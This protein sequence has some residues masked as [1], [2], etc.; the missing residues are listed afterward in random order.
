MRLFREGRFA[1]AL[2]CFDRVLAADPRHTLARGWRGLALVS[3]GELAQAEAEL[4]IAVRESPRDAFLQNGLAGLLIILDRLDEAGDCLRRALALA[5]AFPD[6][7]ANL[8]LVLRLQGDF[9]GSERAGRKALVGLPTHVQARTN[10]AFALLA[11]GKYAEAWPESCA[12]PDP[13]LNPRG[14]VASPFAHASSLPPPGTPVILHAEQG[15]G[16]TLF[17][18]RFVP[19]LKA[20][21]H[22]LAFWGDTRLHSLLAR[23]GLF[24]HFL[25]PEAAPGEGIPL[26]WAGDLPCRLEANDPVRFPP[27]LPLV[28][29]PARQARWRER[30]ATFGAPPYVGV[31]WRAGLERRGT[32]ALAKRME[33]G[34]LGASLAGIRATW[35]SVQ[36]LPAPGEAD[37]F[38]RASGAPLHDASAMND[39][40]EEALALV[41]V[42]DD[43]VGVSNTNTHLRASAGRGGRVL[44]VWP[45]EWRWLAEGE[46]SPWFGSMRLYRQAR[47]GDWSAALAALRADLQAA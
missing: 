13:R 23:T 33:L 21:G 3:L 38:A 22:P 9:A 41:S 24:E 1:P 37:A 25:R 43:Y 40:L 7:L 44:I 2:A 12:R 26:V 39:D 46:R 8:S 11:L 35:I 30:L 16:D 14:A 18:L 10:L 42:L 47:D 29:D 32:L 17:F 31:T 45:P 36:R 6:A 28:P 5:P 27:S 34:D 20:R 19:Q 4:T 15:L